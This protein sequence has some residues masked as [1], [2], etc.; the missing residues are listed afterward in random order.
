MDH[1]TKFQQGEMAFVEGVSR[2]FIDSFYIS[3]GFERAGMTI[4]PFVTCYSFV[5]VDRKLAKVQLVINGDGF[6]TADL[7]FPSLGGKNR[8]S[9]NGLVFD[10][11]TSRFSCMDSDQILECAFPKWEVQ[12]DVDVIRGNL[13]RHLGDPIPVH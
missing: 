5:C 8:D 11:E 1:C 6:V 2:Q 4:V 12:R 7:A 9:M 13:A 3:W 10:I